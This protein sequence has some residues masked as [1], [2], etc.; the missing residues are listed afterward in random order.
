MRHNTCAARSPWGNERPLRRR[1]I[2]SRGR[3]KPRLSPMRFLSPSFN[4]LPGT[5]G[6]RSACVSGS[7][8]HAHTEKAARTRQARRSHARRFRQ[9]HT[10]GARPYAKRTKRGAPVKNPHHPPVTPSGSESEEG[11]RL[12]SSTAALPA[13]GVRGRLSPPKNALFSHFPPGGGWGGAPV[14]FPGCGAPPRLP[15]LSSCLSSLPAFP[16]FLPFL[17]SCLSSLPAFPLFLP[18]L[19]SCLSS[20]PAFPLFLPFLSSCLSS[21][22]A[23]PLSGLSWARHKKG[24]FFRRSLLRYPKSGRQISQFMGM[25]DSLGKTVS[26]RSI[27]ISTNRKGSRFLT[28]AGSL[29]LPMPHTT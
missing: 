23:F 20:L 26:R 10:P 2:Q 18:F 3:I 11:F 1:P 16:L 12:P 21:L 6:K 17:S 29:R 7:E 25:M 13:M 24:S 22:P 4:P 9:K 8:G 27:T 15:F 5:A 28:R 14:P 19:S